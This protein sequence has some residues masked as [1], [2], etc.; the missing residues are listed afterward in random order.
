MPAT[1]KR[2]GFIVFNQREL[3]RVER[4]ELSYSAW[5]AGAL[6]LCYTRLMLNGTEVPFFHK[7]ASLGSIRIGLAATQA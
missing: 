3:E 6:P 5:K 7:A 1:L 2:A 4:I